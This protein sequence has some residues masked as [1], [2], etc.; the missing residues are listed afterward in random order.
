MDET[1]SYTD[2][3]VLQLRNLTKSFD[4]TTVLDSVSLSIKEGEVRAL[5]GENGAG[6]STLIKL[7]SGVYPADSGSISTQGLN[8]TIKAPVDAT[9]SGIATVHQEL[10]IAPGLSVAENVF[11]GSRVSTKF[12][13]IRWSAL[14]REATN[15]LGLLG[16]DFNVRQPVENL[17]AVQMTMTA[18]ARALSQDARVLILDEPTASLSDSEVIQLF[19]AIERLQKKGVGILY[20]S[21]R[22]AE[23]FEIASTYT[24]LRNGVNVA[25][26]SITD[27]DIPRIINA[28]A[29][30][31]IETA[32]PARVM[33]SE[34]EI[35]TVE[36]LCGEK[37]RDLTFSVCEGETLGIAGLA[38]SGRSEI[39]RII[40]GAQRA[41]AG[42]MSINNDNYKPRSIS[43]AH[44]SGVVLVP[45][46][47]RRD[48]LIPGTI[49][50]N[51][52]VTTLGNLTTCGGVVVS[53]KKSSQLALSE[54]KKFDIRGASVSQDVLTLSGGNQQKVVLA[55]FLALGPKI[56]LID[57]PTR[58]VDVS[59]R[60][61]IYRLLAK[62]TSN[63]MAI[64]V[65]SSEL[66]ELLAISHRVLVMHEGRQVTI[67]DPAVTNE[68]AA[69]HACYGRPQ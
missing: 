32:Y 25:E 62:L 41:R 63:G 60:T 17:S 38:G 13:A 28:M 50:S 56:L 68:E 64:V 67:L 19:Q 6:K 21:H 12:G 49:E 66:T 43:D 26:G 55:K 45:Q 52:V 36:G 53:G 37:V 42:E 29:G 48:G 5:L 69:L 65:V 7:V 22:L 30:R 8:L 9:R 10:M 24:V 51:L 59:T 2:K 35:L 33:P 1:A 11:L 15:L 14:N 18:L 34:Q 39:L 3:T 40:A 61:E 47:R 31:S 23:V 46:E 20:V 44:D 27:T 4:G 54:W 57:E 58:G 16:Q